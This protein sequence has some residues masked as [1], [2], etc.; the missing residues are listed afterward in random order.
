MLRNYPAA[1]DEAFLV[2]E[3]PIVF[4]GFSRLRSDVLCIRLEGAGHSIYPF[5]WLVLSCNYRTE[6]T[7]VA[8]TSTQVNRLE[9][10]FPFFG[11]RERVGQLSHI[12]RTSQEELGESNVRGVQPEL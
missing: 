1:L 11:E 6:R 12:Y 9:C 10:L 5:C 8:G 4:Q 2:G 7:A 3:G